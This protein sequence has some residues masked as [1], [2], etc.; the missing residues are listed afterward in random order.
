MVGDHVCFI[1][2]TLLERE[3]CSRNDGITVHSRGRGAIVLNRDGVLRAFCPKRSEFQTL[4][5]TP[6]P[7]HE[8]SAPPPYRGV[9]YYARAIVAEKR[10]RCCNSFIGKLSNFVY[11]L[12]TVG[13]KK[14]DK[15]NLLFTVLIPMCVKEKIP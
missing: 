8:S 11:L 14:S 2:Q 12:H 10:A 5:G 7:K 1:D 6:T 9:H 15:L 3:F 4:R 13:K